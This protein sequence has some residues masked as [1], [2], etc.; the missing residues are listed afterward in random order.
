[1]SKMKQSALVSNVL[2]LVAG[3]AVLVSLLSGWLD[4][5]T[6]V[7]LGSDHID[8]WGTHWFYWMFEE[9]LLRGEP[10]A[11]TDLLFYPWGKDVYLHTG[12]NVVDAL[13]AL[14]FRWTL[15]DTQGY[16]AF[17]VSILLSNGV[18][19]GWLVHRL[20]ATTTASLVAGVLGT[21]QPYP[22]VELSEGRL[23]QAIL[24]F[25]ALFL[26]EWILL[27]GDASRARALR[28]AGWLALTGL[29]YWYY[30]LF[31]G[32]LAALTA[33][34]QW[35]ESRRGG[36]SV[37][38]KR[39][40]MVAAVALVA[41][42][43]LAW[44]MLSALGSDSVP[45]LL[46]VDGWSLSHWEPTTREGYEMGLE[47]FSPWSLSTGTWYLHQEQLQFLSPV[48]S[49]FVSTLTLAV[50]G[51][52]YAPARWRWSFLAGAAL[53]IILAMGPALS[54]DHSNPVYVVMAKLFPPLQRLWWPGRALGILSLWMLPLIGWALSSLGASWKTGLVGLCTVGVL[55]AELERT[56]LTPIPSTSLHVPD[57]VRCMANGS[58]AIIDLPYGS[59][60]ERL[61]Y[62]TV[63]GRARLGGMLES[64][65]VFVPE[66]HTDPGMAA[67]MGIVE[68]KRICSEVSDDSAR[69]IP[70]PTQEE[71]AA[72][73]AMGFSLVVVDRVGLGGRTGAGGQVDAERRA[74]VQLR[75]VL[76]SPVFKSR[77]AVVYQ[78]WG[79]DFECD[80]SSTEGE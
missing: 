34:I 37:P 63:H 53:L 47:A 75:S 60:P 77:E 25:P 76:G 10:F 66:A 12:G 58:G 78:P 59:R 67:L 46:A 35:I 7:L 50:I 9:R 45:G 69:C 72:I 68:G 8:M 41:V 39:I 23:T 52:F 29:I 22:L 40:L 73:G 26:S 43:P 1:M 3:A 71:V 20:G 18:G 55:S 31:C 19:A 4:S 33:G 61:L 64:N 48:R 17:A 42:L 27:F 74:R 56:E 80:S 57:I 65:P 2:V 44:P 32:A 30:A 15:G 38:W 62:Q 21:L 16:N 54:A 6:P 36:D 11:H 24:I 70:R 79:G 5:T 51:L 28:A 14:P 49:I 13:L